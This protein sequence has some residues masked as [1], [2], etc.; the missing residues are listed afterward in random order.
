LPSVH[1]RRGNEMMK[2]VA[3]LAGR[4]VLAGGGVAW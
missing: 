4:A 3:R 1:Q 2:F